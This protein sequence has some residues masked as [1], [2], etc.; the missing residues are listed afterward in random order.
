MCVV[1]GGKGVEKL[2]GYCCCMRG[3]GGGHAEDVQHTSM[4]VQA[5]DIL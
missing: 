3:G 1:G 2:V 5:K 4:C